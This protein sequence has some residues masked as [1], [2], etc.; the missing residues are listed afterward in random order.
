MRYGKTKVT[1]EVSFW[2][3]DHDLPTQTLVVEA[4]P[5]IAHARGVVQ[6]RKPDGKFVTRR[7]EPC[8][9][10]G[11]SESAAVLEA[12]NLALDDA[13]WLAER[14]VEKGL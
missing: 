8:S 9:G 12:R 11:A 13:Q 3:D 2:A 6:I 14:I 1:N 7:T 4:T 10:L 5:W